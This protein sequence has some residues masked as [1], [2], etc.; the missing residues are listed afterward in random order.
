M[1]IDFTEIEIEQIKD[2]LDHAKVKGYFPWKRTWSRTTD[3]EMLRDRE[4]HE[5]ILRKLDIGE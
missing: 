5:I 4:I 1:K 3:K 2:M